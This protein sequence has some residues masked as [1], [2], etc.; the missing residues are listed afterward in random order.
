MRLLRAIVD[1]PWKILLTS[2]LLALSAYLTLLAIHVVPAIS[3]AKSYLHAIKSG[4]QGDEIFSLQQS[5]KRD[6]ENILGDLHVPI[7]GQALSTFDLNF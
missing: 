5:L 7:I 2:S 6:M 3:H 4:A 1:R